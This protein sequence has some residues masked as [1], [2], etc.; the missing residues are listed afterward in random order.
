MMPSSIDWCSSFIVVS[1]TQLLSLPTMINFM[2]ENKQSET[3]VKSVYK[4]SLDKQKQNIHAQ[5]EFCCPELRC[6]KQWYFELLHHTSGV[7]SDRDSK[8]NKLYPT[9]WC[10][11][12]SS[13][14]SRLT[15]PYW[16]CR[17]DCQI[18]ELCCWS[19]FLCPLSFKLTLCSF[20]FHLFLFS[21][22]LFHLFLYTDHPQ[23][24][25]VPLVQIFSQ[26]H[27][28]QMGP[29]HLH[30]LT[31]LNFTILNMNIQFERESD[32][33]LELVFSLKVK[34]SINLVLMNLSQNLNLSLHLNWIWSWIDLGSRYNDGLESKVALDFEAGF[35]ILDWLWML[36]LNLSLRLEIGTSIWTIYSVFGSWVSM[37]ITIQVEVQFETWKDKDK[38]QL[39]TSLYCFPNLNLLQSP[40]WSEGLGLNHKGLGFCAD[41]L[42]SLK[43]LSVT[44]WCTDLTLDL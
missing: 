41:R 9:P 16:P 1:K 28:M 18:D 24:V 11:H 7:L 37:Q 14:V 29:W 34:L 2:V 4:L 12:S 10:E 5:H 30:S 6:P 27:H 32:Y 31:W 33:E 3:A 22:V 19:S 26:A 40:A 36:N 8:R 15:L 20:L 42:Q 39:Q 38:G 17:L 35:Q 21:P 44:D 23:A 25:K 13:V 43:R